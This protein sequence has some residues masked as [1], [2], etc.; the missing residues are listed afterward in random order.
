MDK[1]SVEC[2]R[3]SIKEY[4]YNLFPYSF[5]EDKSEK[6]KKRRRTLAPKTEKSVS[7]FLSLCF[8]CHWNDPNIQLWFHVV[9]QFIDT[10]VVGNSVLCIFSGRQIG[11]REGAPSHADREIGA[12]C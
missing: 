7:L 12:K 8:L 1:P 3:R 4:A 9:W 5:Q 11:D 6:E 10:F 2:F